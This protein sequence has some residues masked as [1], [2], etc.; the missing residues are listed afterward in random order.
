MKYDEN[1]K[2]LLKEIKADLN[3]Q[4]DSH[5]LEGCMLLKRRYYPE[6]SASQCN[7]HLNLRDPFF[8]ELE[9]IL[10]SVKGSQTDKTILKKE[11]QMED[12]HFLISELSTKLQ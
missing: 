10:K 9:L 8:A 5:G 6:Q 7:P 3:K 2:A 12:S 11:K 1:Y 4:T